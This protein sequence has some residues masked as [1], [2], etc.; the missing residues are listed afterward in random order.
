MTQ[1]QP[2]CGADLFL[3]DVVT[4]VT[5]LEVKDHMLNLEARG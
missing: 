2:G 4:V 5:V 1:H 3:L